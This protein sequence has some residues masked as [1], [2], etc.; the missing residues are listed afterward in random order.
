MC[1]SM[2]PSSA[3]E[4]DIPLQDSVFVGSLRVRT[5]P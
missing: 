5:E 2:L 1:N 4:S 3:K